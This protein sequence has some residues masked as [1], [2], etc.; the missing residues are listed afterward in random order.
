MFKKIFSFFKKNKKG[1]SIMEYSMI[2][3]LISIPLMTTFLNI[4][5]KIG[6][7]AFEA[8]KSLAEGTIMGSTP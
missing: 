7:R 6:D 8:M 1:Q 5:D 2:F 4:R 3:V